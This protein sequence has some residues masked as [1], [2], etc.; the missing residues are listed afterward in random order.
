MSEFDGRKCGRPR[1][2]HDI[3]NECVRNYGV[4]DDEVRKLVNDGAK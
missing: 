4:D 2:C 3:M 1:R